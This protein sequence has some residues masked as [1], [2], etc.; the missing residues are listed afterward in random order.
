MIL[1]IAIAHLLPR[2]PLSDKT[3]HIQQLHQNSII[4]FFDIFHGLQGGLPAAE[5]FSEAVERT[6]ELIE[7]FNIEMI[8]FRG[9]EYFGLEVKQILTKFIDFIGNYS[10]D[11]FLQA[12][13]YFLQIGPYS[14]HEHA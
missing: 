3:L 6:L 2:P 7:E 14:L 4:L 12:L 8:Y 11:F 10:V 13:C 5:D 9:A 1:P